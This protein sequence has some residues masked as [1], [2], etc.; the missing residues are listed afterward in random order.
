MRVLELFSHQFFEK[1]VKKAFKNKEEAYE[2]AYLIIVLQTCQHNPNV[3][4]KTDIGSFIESAAAICPLSMEGF[5]PGFFEDI[6]NS[7]TKKPF[8]TPTS[9]SLIDEAF[10]QYTLNEL[11]IRLAKSK[12]NDPNP[13]TESELVNSTDL[14]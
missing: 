11:D 14:T 9:R 10:N 12:W 7:V 8:Y 5:P 6:Y 13:V 1:D 4:N 3:K 2:F